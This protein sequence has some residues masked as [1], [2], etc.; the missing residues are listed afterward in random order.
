M[1]AWRQEEED[2]LIEN[3][4]YKSTK[5]LSSYLNRSEKAIATRVSVLGLNKVNIL[6]DYH[7]RIT[8]M[9]EQ[10]NSV[11]EIAKEFNV[12][13]GYMSRYI[14]EKKLDTN[15]EQKP[16]SFGKI[17]MMNGIE[18][19]IDFSL[20][21]P[22][23]KQYYIYWYQNYR[24]S[25]V[26]E[27]T[28][29][30]YRGDFGAICTHPLADMKLKEVNRGSAQDYLNQYGANRSKLTVLDHWQKLRSLFSDAMTDGLITFNPFTNLKAVYKE[31]QS[32]PKEL[33]K[34]RNEKKS[35][36]MDEYNRLKYHLMFWFGKNLNK[37]PI[38]NKSPFGELTMAE[39][40]S[41]MIIFIALKTGARFSEVIGLTEQDVKFGTRE[42][43][44]DK[45]W[46]YKDT[47]DFTLTKNVSSIRTIEVDSETVELIRRFIDWKNNFNVETHKNTLFVEV[48][49][50]IF[51]STI[52]NHLSKMLKNLKIE[53]ITLHGLRHTHASILIA[54]NVPLQVIAKRLGHTD[55]NMIQRVYGHLLEVTEDEGNRM[56][57]RLI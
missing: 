24:R 6:I 52:N 44:F 39:Q 54:N 3:Y 41:Y 55:T 37:Q 26:R 11:S 4:K 49:A 7:D 9:L 51:N 42:L 27:V 57:M 21:D 53:P 28:K 35:L 16:L 8:R 10:D 29:S 15:L 14:K 38:R 33:K 31:Q 17:A 47:Y 56:I 46:D 25:T 36:E 32:S 1:R 19:P 40:I 48:G 30:K 45:T 23:L 13:S 43:D 18:D 34:K 50:K 2:Y 5:E 12:G 22:T 20:D